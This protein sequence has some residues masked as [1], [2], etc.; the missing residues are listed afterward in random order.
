MAKIRAHDSKGGSDFGRLVREA[1]G[2]ITHPI[3]PGSILGMAFPE[4]EPVVGEEDPLT[5]LP[6]WVGFSINVTDIWYNTG[7]YVNNPM[8]WGYGRDCP[9][10]QELKGWDITLDWTELD[11]RAVDTTKIF[12]ADTVEKV[13][14]GHSGAP[15]SSAP[16]VYPLY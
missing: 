11:I 1:L 15:I 3:T 14:N 6:W 2:E 8:A 13:D 4:D 10:S 9:I 12:T 5:T 16:M 7:V